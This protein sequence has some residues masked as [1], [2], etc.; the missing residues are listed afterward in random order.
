MRRLFQLLIVLLVVLG[1][2]LG[3]VKLR[4]GGGEPYDA[5]YAPETGRALIPVV[6]LDFPLGNVTTSSTGRVFFNLHPFAQAHRFTDAF[7]F[8]LIDGVPKPY[9]DQAS[10]TD[11]ST[12]FGMT[13][14]RMGRL[15]LTCPATLDREQTRLLAYDLETGQRVVE[16]TFP[17]GVARFAQ[18][19]RVT[20]DGRHM[21]MADTGLFR[22]TPAALLVVDLETFD[23]RRVLEGHPSIAPQDWYIT[24]F[25]GTPLKLAYGLVTF[26]VGVDGIEIF[27]DSVVY[28]PMTHDGAY[29]V[30]LAQLVDP[31]VSAND[32]AAAVVRIG[33]KPLSDGIAVAK[34]G[35][36]L[37]TDIEHGA[38]ARLAPDGSLHPFGYSKDIIWSDGVAVTSS[39][40]YVTDSAIPAYIDP[41]ARPPA[42]A[43]IDAHAPYGLYRIALSD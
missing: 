24:T 3:F 42:K 4:Y 20:P 39:V 5:P 8:E 27:G 29:R 15:W 33:S 41:L 10:Q 35:S 14:D 22:F 30:P 16:H 43:D 37:L 19:M 1:V 25:E 32:L 2:F 12:V 7:L 21:I 18:D 36:V 23:A 11:L 31:A 9:P 6:E 40:A 38:L 17:P 26:A 13:V 28:A 34:D